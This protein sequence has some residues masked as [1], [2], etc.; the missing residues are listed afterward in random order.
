MPGFRFGFG[1]GKRR[2]L[3]ILGELRPEL[4]REALGVGPEFPGIAPNPLL[5]GEARK[6][7][8]ELKTGALAVGK[9]VG[10][11][12]LNNTPRLVLMLDV[13]TTDGHSF[14][15]IADEDFTITELTRLAPGQLFAVRYRP[16][17]MDHYVALARDVDPG[18]VN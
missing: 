10:W 4:S 6:R 13:E 9:L 15:G 12:E 14:R 11:H 7:S 16:A 5:S 2:N 8:A 3:D 18:S 1:A 17:H